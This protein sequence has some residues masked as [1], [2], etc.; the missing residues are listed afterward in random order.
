MKGRQKCFICDNKYCDNPDHIIAL[1]RC[2]F[3][4]T[5]IHLTEAG[6]RTFGEN[7]LQQ[8]KNNVINKRRR[9]G[10]ANIG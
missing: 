8:E 10:K 1:N 6:K 4:E 2:Y 7:Y 3:D 9:Q 5:G